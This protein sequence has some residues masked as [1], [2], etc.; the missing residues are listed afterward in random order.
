MPVLTGIFIWLALA[1]ART[2]NRHS[3]QFGKARTRAEVNF[4]HV[5]V[6][7]HSAVWEEPPRH[8]VQ[9]GLLVVLRPSSK[10]PGNPILLALFPQVESSQLAVY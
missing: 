1:R 9:I 2:G 3:R 8:H 4:E 7:K 5:R 10:T 6:E